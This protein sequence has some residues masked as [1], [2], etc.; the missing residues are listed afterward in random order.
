MPQTATSSP[1]LLP[2]LQPILGGLDSVS[3][4][5]STGQVMSTFFRRSSKWFGKLLDIGVLPRNEVPQAPEVSGDRLGQRVWTL[6]D[7][8]RMAFHLFLSPKA[9][10]Y[11]AIALLQTLDVVYAVARLYGM[12]PL[13]EDPIAA[14]RPAMEGADGSRMYRRKPPLLSNDTAIQR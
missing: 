3:Y 7:V 13:N 11:D 1:S 9:P 2:E 4:T 8:E 12:L 14:L 5:G 10:V 6:A